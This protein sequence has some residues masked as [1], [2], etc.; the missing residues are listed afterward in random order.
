[1]QRKDSDHARG[2]S[3][4]AR[5]DGF[6][7]ESTS[8]LETVDTTTGVVFLA[9]AAEGPKDIRIGNSA[10][11]AASRA[12]SYEQRGRSKVPPSLHIDL[13]VHAWNVRSHLPYMR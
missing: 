5:T 9:G 13:K 1:M 3:L 2:S 8:K 11:A 4:I 10:S 12:T 7:L 6:Y